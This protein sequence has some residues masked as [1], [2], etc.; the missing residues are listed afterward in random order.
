MKLL[1]TCFSSFLVGSANGFA[2]RGSVRL[3]SAAALERVTRRSTSALRQSYLENLSSPSNTINIHQ[4]RQYGSA[5]AI[6]SMNLELADI[7]ANGVIETAKRNGFAPI[8]VT[9][10][11]INANSIVQKRMDGPVHAA[12]P[13]FSL[14][15]AFTCVSMKTSS[16]EFRDKYTADGD[17]TKMA[18][19]T[20]M[21]SIADM[22]AFPGGVLVKN[23]LGDVVGAIGV[24][25]A[26]GDEDEY[27]ALR[28]VWDSGLG[29][30]TQPTE[31]S[32]STAQD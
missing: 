12:F 6:T 5:P 16:R 23:E 24:S 15:K 32:C 11:D 8:V 17:P 19:L 3:Q 26:A 14:A 21:M 10:L 1:T 4:N 18:Q 28:S 30:T 22:A 13:E 29:L 27:C 20:S 2:H 31:H 25:G 7:L 9:V